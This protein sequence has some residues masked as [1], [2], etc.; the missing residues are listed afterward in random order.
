MLKK[1]LLLTSI[2][3]IIFG[4]FTVAT[5]CQMPSTTTTTTTTISSSIANKVIIDIPT[6]LTTETTT[7]TSSIIE[8]TFVVSPDQQ[9]L[10]TTV[11]GYYSLVRTQ[12]RLASDLSK[13]IKTTLSNLETVNIN[14]IPLFK[15][16][17]TVSYTE[18]S[19][20]NKLKFTS[21]G[22]DQYLL[23]YWRKQTS[24]SYEKF[25]EMPFT[26]LTSGGTVEV[27]GYVTIDTTSDKSIKSENGDKKPELVRI[28]FDSN[29]NSTGKQY[30][31]VSL[32][33]FR[34]HRDLDQNASDQNGIVELT[35]NT[36][37]SIEITGNIM[38]PGSRWF[39]WNGYKY[40]NTVD[41]TSA[42]ETRYY[43]FTG[44]A[45]TDNKATVNLGLAE[46]TYTDATV[47]TDYSIGTVIK[48]LYT[49]RLNNNYAFESS[50]NSYGKTIITI[51]N[52]FNT[53][54][55]QYQLDTTNYNN[56][57]PE[58]VY[59]AIKNGVERASI[60]SQSN[61]MVNY[62]LALMEVENPAYFVQNDYSGYGS[63]APTGFITKAEIDTI[64]VIPKAT[65]T[66][67]TVSFDNASDDAGF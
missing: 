56:N 10:K 43:V 23:E 39:V 54:Y 46:S 51:L 58:K 44:K 27:R 55:P 35:K 32:Y 2:V 3:S 60:L 61:Y 42:S 48:R 28:D 9:L 36:D 24:G 13:I 5:G 66:N 59:A 67:L 12:L 33:K 41:T 50:Q 49:D 38:V 25:F 52:T 29:L 1:I 34:F 20:Q 31:K 15:L 22:N 62:L 37:G 47:F 7:K 18:D 17:T 26:Y 14:N 21:K 64:N 53:G 6:S 19:T 11:S 4:L 16:T 65:V 40:D 30:M 45:T 8:K 57:T 63:T